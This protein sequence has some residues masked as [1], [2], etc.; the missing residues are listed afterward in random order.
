MSELFYAMT[1]AVQNWRA[2]VFND[3]RQAEEH[4]RNP[5]GRSG[6]LA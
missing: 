1:T 4:G 3:W 6:F 5:E 2:D